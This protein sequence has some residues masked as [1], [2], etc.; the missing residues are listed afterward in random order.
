MDKKTSGIFTDTIKKENENDIL[1]QIFEIQYFTGSR[2]FSG[3][4]VLP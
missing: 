4:V 2:D 3:M 1:Q